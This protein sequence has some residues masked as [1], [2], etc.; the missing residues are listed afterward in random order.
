[1]HGA[2]P[3]LVAD[4]EVLR[5]PLDLFAVQQEITAPPAL[6][7][8]KARLLGVDV[9]EHLVVLAQKV[10]AGFRFSKFCTRCAPSNLPAP[11]SDVSEASQVPPQQPSGIAHRIVA[12][13][14]APG[15]APVGHRRADDHDRTVSSG[16]AAASIIAAQPAWQLPTIPGFGASG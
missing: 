8:E 15:A 9:G 5:D 7:L 12:L 10:L 3:H 13:A 4:E 16:L 6:E 14:L 2:G 1:L 11:R